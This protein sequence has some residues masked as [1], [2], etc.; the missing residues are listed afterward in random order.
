MFVR[1]LL[2][3]VALCALAC[4]AVADEPKE[5]KLKPVA[6]FRGSHSAIKEE[7]FEVVATEDEWKKLWE[8]HRGK[9]RD[10]LF[11][12]T[13]QELSIDFETHYIVA[14]FAGPSH[15]C[16]P[17]PKLR[18]DTVV[19]QYEHGFPQVIAGFQE[20]W[21]DHEKAKW[22]AKCSYAFVVLPKPVKTVVIEEGVRRQLSDPFTWKERAKFP[23]PKDRK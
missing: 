21:T 11:T 18:G 10:S 7:T 13:S 8:K 4:V 12:E 16:I 1:L 15:W 6:V 17:R 19:I 2:V 22:D 23:A 9:E 20:G 3:C 14:L 5:T